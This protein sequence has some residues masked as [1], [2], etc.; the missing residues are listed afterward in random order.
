MN[1]LLPFT[2]DII[3][4]FGW[5]LL[6]SFWQAFFVYA[7]LRIVLRI[8]PM[9]SA[10]IKYHLSFL[11][12]AGIAGWF[13]VTF[14]NQL[15]AIREAQKIQEM[16]MT[17]DTAT[18]AAAMEQLPKQSSGLQTMLP[19]MESYFPLLV[20]VYIVGVTLMTIKLCLDLAQLRQMRQEGISAM[21]RTWDEHLL[22]LAV[23][24]GVTRKVQLFISQHLQVPVMIGF[25]KPVILLP[26]AMV[27][28]LSPEQLEAIL[29]HELAH[30][31]RNDYLLNIFQSIV[32]TILFFNPFVW[33]ISKNIRLEREHCCD[34]LVI[35]GT[36][37]P[38]HYAKA[39][40]ALEEYRLTANPMAMAAADD[41]HH[42]LHR[43]KRIMEMK[44]KNLN[45]SQRVLAL[46]IIVVGLVSIAWLNP[47]N[48]NEKKE[49]KQST[50][51][52]V[53]ATDTIPL[54][55]PAPAPSPAAKPLPAPAPAA[56]LPVP[57][58]PGAP[59]PEIAPLASPA[60]L[61]AVAPLAPMAPM[62]PPA[63]ISSVTF[64]AAPLPPLPPAA[65]DYYTAYSSFF[66]DGDTTTP[67][68]RKI[69]VK[70][71]DGVEKAYNSITEMPEA[72]RKKMEENYIRMQQLYA[73]M[74][75]QQQQQRNYNYNYSYNYDKAFKFS[76]DEFRKAMKAAEEA[77]KKT[78]WS[79]MGK[80]IEANMKKIDWNKM[81]KE[82][83]ENMKKWNADHKFNEIQFNKLQDEIKRNFNK[84]DWEKINKQMQE[85]LKKVDWDKINKQMKESMEKYWADSSRHFQYFR[86]RDGSYNWDEDRAKVMAEGQISRREAMREAARVRADV[87][88]VIAE[89][90]AEASRVQA[91]AR[92]QN[93][94]VQAEARAQNAR[95]QAE[96]R[97]H[98]E[99][100]VAEQTERNNRI[101]AE[102][103]A[104]ND[105]IRAE[106]N[107]RNDKIRAEQ[108]ER[109]NK[110]RAEQAAN[111]EIRRAEA[112][113]RAKVA[114]DRR[115]ALND[116]LEG[117]EKDNLL[118]RSKDYE[119]EK[120][121]DDL[122]INGKKQPDE[123]NKKY[124]QYLKNKNVSIKKSKDNYHI[125]TQDNR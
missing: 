6:H 106:Q 15:D 44:T 27:S 4:A 7:C 41:K 69:I 86:D 21:G 91:E 99:R 80:D 72:D 46:L 122:Y 20:A 98:N 81:N 22:K 79:K 71:D 57:T 42:L 34:D 78:D 70:G 88:K 38:L 32:E 125:N 107:E 5:T 124:E 29:L 23:N 39:L 62:S 50:F 59:V 56:P 83:A 53:T 58:P 117:M 11:S 2:T 43:I 123:V 33:W 54:P 67:R 114:Q 19:G 14:Y 66:A 63:P 109:N 104:N 60:P 26:A 100:I 8:W 16:A 49:K 120:K 51:V 17:W 93:S 103:R 64:N 116:M 48:K 35:A 90:R 74:Q 108:N 85:S 77:I 96:Q 102:Q 101:M 76:K 82:M 40:V 25:L 97:T 111:A 68:S 89:Q 12:L 121:G 75:K 18:I 92:A 36:V 28:N 24:M 47:G 31:K 115:D 37:Q 94:R 112:E 119:I 30:I 3:R 13:L 9:A 10:A 1:S 118:D 55:P 110:I 105:K 73:D 52:G 61:P 45:Y 65:P 95:I 84:A 87:D 113:K